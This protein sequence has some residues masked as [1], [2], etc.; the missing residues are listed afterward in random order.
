[1]EKE[2]TNGANSAEGKE[3]IKQTEESKMKDLT[4][5]KHKWSVWEQLSGGEKAHKG[6]VEK[7]YMENMQEIAEFGDLISFWQLWHTI[8]HANPAESF[9]FYH[10]EMQT[11]V[12]HQ[13]VHRVII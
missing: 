1:M 2:P 8:P 10:D 6:L 11:S 5:L 12:Q 3:E 13:Y 4:K 7:E 9:A